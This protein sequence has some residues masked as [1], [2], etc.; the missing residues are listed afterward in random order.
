MLLTEENELKKFILKVSILLIIVLTILGI[1]NSIYNEFR[2][3]DQYGDGKFVHVPYDIT[4]SNTGSS[5]GVYALDY[6]NYEGEQTGFNFALLSQTLSYDYR[7]ISEYKDHF[8]E[9][10]I[11]FIP[12]SYPSF[13]FDETSEDDFESKNERYYRFLSPA[14][15]KE[16]DL[17]KYLGLHY[18]PATYDSTAGVIKIFIRGILNRHPIIEDS[19]YIGERHMNFAKDAKRA[20]ESHIR[21]DENGIM[22]TNQEEIDALY[23]IINFCY[24][25]SIRPILIS[26]PLRSEYIEYY[27]P[28]VLDQFRS[29][30]Q[31]VQDDTGCEYYDYTHDER[32][33]HSDQNMRNADHLSPDGA[34]V[35]TEILMNEVVNSNY[36]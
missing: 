14:N 26:T 21:V 10:G 19:D 24:E 36:N 2:S 34:I 11:M 16:F 13:T 31:K 33:I 32:F 6:S 3:D 5:H 35:F 18:F 25:H 27:D 20:Y 30:V 28:N 29:I 8:K 9:G 7:V 1:Y 22:I 15:I 4:I 17:G 12:V 23:D